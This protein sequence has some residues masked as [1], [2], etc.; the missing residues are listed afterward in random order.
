[1]LQTYFQ[2]LIKKLKNNIIPLN[3]LKLAVIFWVIWGY[4]LKFGDF[5]K[6][7]SKNRR[8]NSNSYKKYSTSRFR[9]FYREFRKVCRN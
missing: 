7:P 5:K 3:F 4:V 2:H 1:M 8:A 6:L 9:T